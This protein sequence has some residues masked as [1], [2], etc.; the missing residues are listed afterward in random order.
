VVNATHGLRIG[1]QLPEAEYE[2]GW[3]DVAAMARLAED[4]GFDSLWV[5]DHLL[6]RAPDRP[7]R[8][9]WEAWTQLA[10]L[11]AITDRVLLGPLVAA[12][13]FHAPAMLAK[14]A[15]TVDEI[16]GGRLILGLGA[17]WNEVEFAAFG[18]PYDRRVA[19]FAEA[20]EIIRRLVAGERVTF[21]GEFHRIDDCVLLPAP[22][23]GGP[24]LLI[25]SMGPRMLSITAPHMTMWNA[26]YSWFGNRPEGLAPLQERVDAALIAAGRDPA[27][28]ER[29]A[30]VLVAASRAGGRLLGDPSLEGDEPIRGSTDQVAQA[31]GAFAEAGIGE[32]QIVLDPI[33]SQAIEEIAPAVAAAKR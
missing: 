12:T 18:F 6:Y 33:T 11:A 29:S 19:R 27:E 32:L 7:D 25:G 28:V 16:S 8:G 22:R 14:Q 5:G 20:F 17:G 1:L 30:A 2:A 23:A 24:P 21:E 26:W 10:G 15:A 31:L 3:Q 9:P 4:A 13:A